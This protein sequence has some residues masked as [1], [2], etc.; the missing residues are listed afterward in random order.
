MRLSSASFNRL[1]N[2]M[3]QSFGW[4][5]SY[6]CPCVNPH[7]GQAK[8]NC[9]VCAGKGRL[10]DGARDGIAGVISR[11]QMKNFAAFGVWDAGD[12]MLS[13]P[14]DSLLYQI[15]Q[16][17]RVLANNRSEPFS[18]NFVRGTNDLVRFP[19]IA[20]D[21]AYYLSGDVPVE[22]DVL[23][24]LP[25]GRIQW[26]ASAPPVGVT[27]SVT[28]RRTPEYFCYQELPADRPMHHGEPLPRRIVLRRFDLFGR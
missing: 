1:L 16:F 8:P 9:P 18:L 23:G 22:L 6:A 27:Y 13:I 25:D 21:R 3:G 11:D 24:V 28:G 2:H 10:W 20:V 17:D 5:R 19:I 7:S 4:R 12:I 15:G 26:G 14:S